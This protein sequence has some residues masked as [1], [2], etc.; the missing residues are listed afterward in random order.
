M[1]L[2]MEKKGEFKVGSRKKV[3]EDV[4]SI[5]EYFKS[6]LLLNPISPIVMGKKQS[7]KKQNKA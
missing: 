5:P 3:Y 2:E 1:V 6:Q 4:E 7:V